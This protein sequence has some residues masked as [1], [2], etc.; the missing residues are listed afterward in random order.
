MELWWSDFKTYIYVYLAVVVMVMQ[1][2]CR[3]R[4]TDVAVVVDCGA[5]CAVEMVGRVFWVLQCCCC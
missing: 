1:W 2:S 5:G 4:C 3:L